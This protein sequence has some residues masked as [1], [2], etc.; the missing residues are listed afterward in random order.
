MYR[1]LIYIHELKER[2]EIY[3]G[4]QKIYRPE[5]FI[6]WDNIRNMKVSKIVSQFPSYK[7]T[8]IYN[9]VIICVHT[10]VYTYL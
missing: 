5:L 10:Y 2:I 9:Y 4:D 1:T 8:V 3:K 6:D 7:G